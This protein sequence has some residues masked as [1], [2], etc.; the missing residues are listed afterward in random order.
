MRIH[1]RFS[2]FAQVL[3]DQNVNGEVLD[4]ISTDVLL[5]LGFK[6]GDSVLFI[7]EIDQLK[8][9]FNQGKISFGPKRTDNRFGQGLDFVGTCKVVFYPQGYKPNLFIKDI[10]LKQMALGSSALQYASSLD[11]YGILSKEEIAIIYMYTVESPFYKELN[12]IMRE[13]KPEERI[14]YR[15]YI[16]YMNQT[17]EKLSPHKGPV[18]RGI[19]CVLPDYKQGKVITWQAFSSATKNPKV[20]LDFVGKTKTGMLFMIEPKNAR[21]IEEFSALPTEEEVLFLPNSQFLIKSEISLANRAMLEKA[22]G[23]DL[24][25]LSIFDLSQL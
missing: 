11:T 17:L 24:S 3:Y 18:Y 16:Y 1:K 20:A 22:I 19:S 2:Q 21:P 14:L 10:I 12:R 8:K 4:L 25:G 13:G 5:S 9:K 23:V 7:N 6:I 15:D